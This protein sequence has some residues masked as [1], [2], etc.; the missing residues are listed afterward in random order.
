[1]NGVLFGEHLQ[2]VVWENTASLEV[3]GIYLATV[4]TS[5]P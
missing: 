4:A 3:P 5:V 1:M 2:V